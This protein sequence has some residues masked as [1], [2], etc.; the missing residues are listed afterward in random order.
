MKRTNQKISVNGDKNSFQDALIAARAREEPTMMFL[1]ERRM[2]IYQ[3]VTD[4]IITAMEAGVIKGERRWQGTE[5]L[6]L[7]CNVQT[8]KPYSGINVLI[9]WM[10]AKH[11]GYT[12]NHWLTYK[13]AQALGGRVRKG[14]KGELCVYYKALEKET[15][16]KDS[17]V[18]EEVTVPM[19]KPFWLFNLDQ[20]DGISRPVM[21]MPLLFEVMEEAEHILARSG[22]AIRNGGTQAY[23]R[24][25]LD[26]IQLPDRHRFSK[27]ENYYAVA[28]HELT[29]WTGHPTRQHRDF[30][31]RFGSQAYAF[32][33]LVAEL[34]SAFLTAELHLID[35]TLE[36]HASY[37][38]SWLSVLRKDKRAIFTAAK[39]AAKAHQFIMAK[40]A[41]QMMGAA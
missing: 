5:Q 25:A 6:G 20:I 41:E 22:A 33:E 37:L 17:G 13:Q 39:L 28:L 32:E 15:V 27:A 26:I 34:G 11:A 40:T 19:I 4:K 2:D 12:S 3:A 36:G 23:Y 31:G 14:E 18:I 21:F 9:L 7:P 30:T 1:E 38:D 29:H 10:A 35:A 8:G 16:D 24:P